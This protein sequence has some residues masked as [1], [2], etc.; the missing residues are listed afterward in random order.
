MV[1][2]D[3]VGTGH[4]RCILTGPEGGRLKAIAFRAVD[5]D[6]GQ[7]LLGAGSRPMHLAGAIRVD[8]WNG[9]V[10]TQLVIDD[11]AWPV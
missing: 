5:S 6:L 2:A 3:V 1:R 4:V 11:A 10:N 9:A 7:A 8:S